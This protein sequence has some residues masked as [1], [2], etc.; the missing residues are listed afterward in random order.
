M[1]NQ[2]LDAISS[3]IERNLVQIWKIDPLRVNNRTAARLVELMID[4]YHFNDETPAAE[5]APFEDCF[6]F[7][8][9]GTEKIFSQKSPVQVVKVLAAVYRSIERRSDGTSYLHFISQLM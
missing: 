9:Q 8:L 7:M 4:K 3:V 5:S 1:D 6:R 2:D